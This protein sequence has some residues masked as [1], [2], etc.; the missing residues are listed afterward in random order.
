MAVQYNKAQHKR[1]RERLRFNLRDGDLCEYCGR[2]MYRKAENNFDRR[3]VQADHLN[4]DLS[5]E[6]KRL[7]HAACNRAIVNA[8]VR[9]GPG[10]YATHGLTLPDDDLSEQGAG[11]SLPW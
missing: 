3:T 5:N 2:P 1:A 8:W 6:P 7:I 9:H 11:R 10:W 4:A